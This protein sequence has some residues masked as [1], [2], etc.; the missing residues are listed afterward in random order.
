MSLKPPAYLRPDDIMRLPARKADHRIAY[1]AET[2]QFGDL[3]LPPGNGPFPVA[4][5]VHGGCWI[6][7]FANIDFMNP[8]A[9][10]LTHMGI[11]TWNIEYRCVDQVGGGWPGTFTDVGQAVDYLRT[12]AEHFPLDLQRVLM[13]GHSAGGHLGHWAAARH[14]LPKD[15]PLAASNPL[16]IHGVLNLGGTGDV[17]PFLALQERVCNDTPINKLIGGTPEEVPERY[18]QASPIEL[19]PLGIRQVMLVG[20]H[21]E[22]V[23]SELSRQYA[24]AGTAAGDDVTCTVIKNAAHFEII[25]PGTAAWL[26]IEAMVCNLLGMC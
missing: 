13:L 9:D 18:R 23:P 19:L 26:E 16:P 7:H 17:K 2:L 24:E 25:A 15:S 5:V 4:I 20:E 12:L 6:S 8:V 14:R 11:A 10:A 22:S 3:R 1:G 21:D